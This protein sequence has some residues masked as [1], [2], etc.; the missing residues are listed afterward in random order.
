MNIWITGG[1]G[2]VG[3]RLSA[4]LLEMGHDVVAV[5]RRSEFD[6]IRHDNF[7]YV[8]ADTRQE[9]PWQEGIRDAD[10]VVNLTGRSIFG[11]WTDAVKKEI[12]DSRVETTRN[13]V[14][15]LEDEPG[16]EM[17]LVSTSAVGYYGDGGDEILTEA[18]PRGEGFLADLSRDWEAEAMA[19]EAK[20]VRVVIPR[21]GIVLDK[22]G[23]ALKQMLTP[24]KLGLGGPLGDGR[25]WFPWIHMDD[26]LSAIL[27]AL[28]EAKV[29]GPVNLTAPNPVQNRTF[30][31]AL[32]RVLRRPAFVPV[33]GCVVKTAFGELGEVL[34]ASQRVLPVRLLDNGFHF[35]YPDIGPA[36]KQLIRG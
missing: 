28:T 14:A 5:G 29:T 11:Y 17:V 2:F 16:R 9:G 3:T 15:A 13:I 4:R 30:V 32:G 25:H 10:A 7:R 1:S 33:P 20:G 18:S 23:G 12:Y 34:L 31:K 6:D 27:F 26:L 19:A 35:K 22:G 36:L 21:F 8:S 24:F